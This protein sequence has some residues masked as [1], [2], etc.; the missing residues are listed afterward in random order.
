M[1]H[2]DTVLLARDGP[3]ATLTLNRPEALNVLDD[4]MVDALVA[5]TAGVASDASIR[6]VVLR[7]AGRHFMAG[8]DIRVFGQALAEPATQ[9]VD[10]FRRLLERVHAAVE[11]LIRMPQ[12]V[13]AGVQGAVAGFGMSLANAADLVLAADDAYFASAYLQLGVT[14]DGG[15]TWTLPR[16]VGSRRAAEIMMLGDRFDAGEAR[17]LGIVNR[18]VPSSDL[19]ATVAATA[20]RLAAAPAFAM[21]RLKRLLRE[22]SGRTLSEQ[23]GAEAASF[24]ACTGSD[25]FVEGVSAFL[26]KRKPGFNRTP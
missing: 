10:A 26:A 6:V 2:N 15:G 13:V 19:D 18:V 5:H 14:P 3:V 22:S 11:T 12:P 8:G 7:G 17:T 24:S 4:A 23:L 16:I 21:Q 20:E 25:D 1:T 9:R